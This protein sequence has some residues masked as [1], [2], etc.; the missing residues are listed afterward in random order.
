MPLDTFDDKLKLVQVTAWQHQ[1]ITWK[2]V[3]QILFRHMAS[4]GQ[5]ELKIYFWD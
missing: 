1:A 2:N 4:L 3:D 5:S